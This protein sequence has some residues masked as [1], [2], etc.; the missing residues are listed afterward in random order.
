LVHEA[1]KLLSGSEVEFADRAP[2]TGVAEMG[3]GDPWE[4]NIELQSDGTNSR[5]DLLQLDAA[6]DSLVNER[7]ALAQAW[8]RRELAQRRRNRH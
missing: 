4:T 2:P 8:L 7:E 3:N 6:L 5:L 1:L